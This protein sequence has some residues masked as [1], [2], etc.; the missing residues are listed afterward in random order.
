MVK[1]RAHLV[2][3]TIV[4][5]NGITTTVW[6]RAAPKKKDKKKPK[7]KKELEKKDI[8]TNERNYK[9][10]STDELIAE[11]KELGIEWKENQDPRINRMRVIMK[12]KEYYASN[13]VITTKPVSTKEP[14]FWKDEVEASKYGNIETTVESQELAREI[15]ILAEDKE[16]QGYLNKVASTLHQ[17]S[18]PYIEA[19]EAFSGMTFSGESASSFIIRTFITK[20]GT[21]SPLCNV[22]GL[23]VETGRTV[24]MDIDCSFQD[25]STFLS[26]NT[27]T[28]R[29]KFSKR[30]RDS[31]DFIRDCISKSGKM[32]RE[33]FED[34]LINLYNSP[35][36]TKLYKNTLN[37]D[38]PRFLVNYIM[39]EN[40]SIDYSPKD[41]YRVLDNL[42]RDLDRAIEGLS[43][44]SSILKILSKSQRDSLLAILKGCKKSLT[45][46]EEYKNFMKS[47]YCNGDYWS[48]EME[49]YLNDVN[50]YDQAL[51]QAIENVKK[52][53]T[54]GNKEDTLKYATTLALIKGDLGFSSSKDLFNFIQKSQEYFI[55]EGKKDNSKFFE[56]VLNELPIDEVYKRETLEK[57]KYGDQHLRIP[58]KLKNFMDGNLGAHNISAARRT[59]ITHAMGLANATFGSAPVSIISSLAEILNDSKFL[60][61]NI[62][63]DTETNSTLQNIFLKLKFLGNPRAGYQWLHSISREISK[64][65]ISKDFEVLV[66][67]LG[68]NYPEL[69]KKYNKIKNSSE[70][71]RMIFMTLL[72]RL[73]TSPSTPINTSIK[74]LAKNQIATLTYET[75]SP[76]VMGRIEDNLIGNFT[77]D[78][79]V[80]K[81]IISTTK[82]KI[83]EKVK[84]LEKIITDSPDDL[85]I[86]LTPS[87]D[88][89]RMGFTSSDPDSKKSK[90]LMEF[91]NFY[92][93]CINCYSDILTNGE[94][95]SRAQIRSYNTW[96]INSSNI[97]EYSKQYKHTEKL[98][99]DTISKDNLISSID[100][101]DWLSSEE[102]EIGKSLVE[103]FY[104]T[105]LTNNLS[106]VSSNKDI[107][108]SV[109]MATKSEY[110][111]IVK[112]IEASFDHKEHG[113]LKY[114]VK[115]VYKINNLDVRGSL[116]EIIERRAE[117]KASGI[118]FETSGSDKDPVQDTFYHGTSHTTLG[119]ILGETG[120]FRVPKNN[121]V[122]TGAM[123]GL[124]IYLADCSSKSMQYCGA[125]FRQS[126]SDGTKGGALIVCTA[127]V[128][129]CADF[130]VAKDSSSVTTY[131]DKKKHGLRNNEWC[132]KDEN[133]VA[134]EFI[135]D[136]EIL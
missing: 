110:D 10:V 20:K 125:G 25:V 1:N 128:G 5:K 97:G 64:Y 50:E 23:F 87:E 16:S 26:L 70:D 42:H 45:P 47:K 57:I 101:A 81:D 75:S 38:I 62:P 49:K 107:K 54:S 30:D 92:N 93:E 105:H 112:D 88:T 2:K 29:I 19:L 86:K 27:T 132:V 61:I 3:K 134:P 65:T 18:G 84:I 7:A 78:K 11:A 76:D 126:N 94:S 68:E 100:V 55:S 91:I 117:R 98:I 52:G 48:S 79:K 40:G 24:P 118:S 129:D 85:E 35:E 123:M 103:E 71:T 15:G 58:G 82:Q 122:V 14:E 99:T 114:K 80:I 56:K 67:K 9:T 69:L 28:T 34:S 108:C 46:L 8:Q 136:I 6:V 31:F 12:L 115:G 43:K 130:R 90:E 51:E 135:V 109:R 36:L 37:K 102:K 74:K 133:A 53:H 17:N 104:K 106:D 131:G 121:E 96:R 113:G 63:C 124:G 116:Q 32:I 73:K 66:N 22:G 60:G 72:D 95:D 13:P 41:I 83:N 127:S 21:A 120:K 111:K 77:G 59:A 33:D 39:A 119:K 44:K 4:N 89:N